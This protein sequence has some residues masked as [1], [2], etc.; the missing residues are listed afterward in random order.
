M[1]AAY[2]DNPG[3]LRGLE[4]QQVPYVCGVDSSFGVRLPAEVRAAEAAAPPEYRGN[5]RPRLRRPA[6]LHTVKAVSQAIPEKAWRTIT[7]R[8]G[9]KGALRKQFAAVR[10]HRATGN[11][12]TEGV[13]VSQMTTGPEGWLVMERPL[14]GEKGD[15][16]WYYSNLPAKTTL[17][18]LAALAHARWVIEQ[19]YRE[20]KGVCGLDNYQG[21][22]WHGL[23]RHLAL[24]MLSYTFL[25]EQR[26]NTSRDPEGGFSPLWLCH[27]PTRRAQTGVGLAA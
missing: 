13:R 7:W 5:G 3:F 1:D 11:P 4:E 8:E 20:A 24:V 22:S 12:A 9:T 23:H 15:W 18:R 27:D 17:K 14:P 19:F 16:K 26:G 6:P 2:G 10:V 21:R 25:V